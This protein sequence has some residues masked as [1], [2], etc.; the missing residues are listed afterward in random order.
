M[1]SNRGKGWRFTDKECKNEGCVN[2]FI[3]YKSTDK[4]CSASCAAKYFK[5]L[6]K[7]PLKNYN[8][9]ISKKPSPKKAAFEKEFSIAKKHIQ[10]NLI[11]MYGEVCCEKCYTSSSISFSTHHII[12]RSEK[13]SHKELNNP[14]NL[15]YLCYECHESFHKDKKSRNYLISFRGLDSL[16]NQPIW[17]YQ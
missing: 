7:T 17:G 14:L 11:E 8:T 10:K 5:P 3:Q 2:R 6:K 13:P 15:I 4:Y 1:I 9:P 12:F 16:F